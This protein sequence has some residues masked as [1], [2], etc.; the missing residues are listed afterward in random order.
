MDRSIR[1]VHDGS[2][3][4]LR[5][6]TEQENIL[7]LV[8]PVVLETFQDSPTA[9]SLAGNRTILN[10]STVDTNQSETTATGTFSNA[11]GVSG[12]VTDTWTATS[13]T[14]FTVSRFVKVTSAPTDAG[15]R[16]GLEL[17]PSF[18]EGNAFNDFE[19]Y[20]PNACYNL[21][22]L[23]EDGVDDY[24][25]TQTLSYREDRL[26]AL[27]VLAYHPK[28]ELAF[29]LSRANRPEYDSWPARSK[30]QLS[31]LQDTDIGSLGFQP[32]GKGALHDTLLTASYPFVE[33]DRCNALLV[34]ERTPWGAFRPVKTGDSFSVS[35]SVRIYHASSAHDALWSLIR[36][37]FGVLKP[38]PVDLEHS[39]EEI[40][41]LRLEALVPYYMEDSTGA[42][43]FVTN[44]HPQDGKQ[45]GNVVQYG[46]YC[47]PALLPCNRNR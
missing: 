44:C 35:Y 31:F 39:I 4:T 10:Y 29:T 5:W 15:I 8:N 24:L 25:N 30:G 12:S 42:A 32:N 40:S 18:P 26:N 21:N 47:N 27:S 17:R 11:D 16:V 2:T 46:K 45:L 33:R 38:K 3:N 28:R 34:Q 13:S 20:A 23:N 1:L 7:S 36:Q 43:G 19:Y 6:E 14:I 9:S 22:D 41:R 37:Q